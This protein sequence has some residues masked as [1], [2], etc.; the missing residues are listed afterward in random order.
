MQLM[1]V[2]GS[3]GFVNCV[4]VSPATSQDLASLSCA[5]GQG[6][7]LLETVRVLR[8]IESLGG[9]ARLRKGA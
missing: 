7:V 6:T 9:E 8:V 1:H 5:E 3:T 2:A 4:E